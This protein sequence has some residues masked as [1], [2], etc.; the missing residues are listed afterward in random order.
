MP[1]GLLQRHDAGPITQVSGYVDACYSLN[2]DTIRTEYRQRVADA[3]NRTQGYIVEHDISG[4]TDGSNRLEE[5]LAHRMFLEQTALLIPDWPPMRIVD[6]QTPLKAK[7]TDEYGKIDLLA[8]GE[9]LC[10]VE[11]KVLRNDGTGDTPLN[12]LLE[13]VGYCAVVEANRA[14]IIE[15]LTATGHRVTSDDLYAL[16]LAPDD[17]WARWDRRDEDWR[18]GLTHAAEVI[19]TATGLRVG[20]GSFDASEVGATV[21][22]SDPTV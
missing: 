3:P 5:L 6:F 16:V 4:R 10:V 15:E 13:A 14:R 9:G 20:Y 12:A 2:L 7:Q 18:G 19:T 21:D 8:A 22:V 1:D 11:L 17:Y